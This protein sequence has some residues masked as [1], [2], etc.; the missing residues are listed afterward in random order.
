MKNKLIWIIILMQIVTTGKAQ[1][2]K[3]GLFL[4]V[5]DFKS[6]RISLPVDCQHRKKAIRVRDFFL[7]PYVYIH[8]TGGK[9]K[10]PE[11]QVYAFRDCRNNLYR[12]QDG[13]AYLICDTS[14]LKIYRYTHWKTIKVRTSRMLRFR[15]KRVT[16]Y[17]FSKN[18]SSEVFLLTVDH[19]TAAFK[20]NDQVLSLLRKNFSDDRS[21]RKKQN[22]R[23]LIN[24][25]LSG[26]FEKEPGGQDLPINGSKFRNSI[27]KK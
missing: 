22:G 4:S 19:L 5:R 18:D 9:Q 1:D 16:D 3:P 26:D 2:E 27:I 17:F 7:H 21:L 8:T 12:L 25:Y 6:N 14:A 10:I 13:K 11:D 20:G 23:F 15:D 24:Q